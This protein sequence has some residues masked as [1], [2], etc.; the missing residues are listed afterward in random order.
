MTGKK[1]VKFNNVRR[2]LPCSCSDKY[3][4]MPVG[5]QSE[6]PRLFRSPPGI[7]FAQHIWWMARANRIRPQ[8][9]GRPN[10]HIILTYL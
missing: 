8:M 5:E 2:P 7:G 3:L 10:I 1:I 4:S 6:R 9:N